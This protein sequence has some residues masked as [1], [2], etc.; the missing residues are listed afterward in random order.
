M[1]QQCIWHSTIK[2]FFALFN[3]QWLQTHEHKSKIIL[4]SSLLWTSGRHEKCDWFHPTAFTHD[5][6]H[7]ISSFYQTTKTKVHEQLQLL[8]DIL[9]RFLAKASGAWT[10]LQARTL[11]QERRAQYVHWPAHLVNLVVHDVAQNLPCMPQLFHTYPWS[12]YD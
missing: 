9:R 10:C 8:N 4:F 3:Q 6:L 5:L 1:H 11:G 12:G 7:S 2:T